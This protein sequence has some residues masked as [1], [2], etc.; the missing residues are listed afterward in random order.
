MVDVPRPGAG[1]LRPEIGLVTR[2]ILESG[3]ALSKSR[4]RLPTSAEL[5]LLDLLW[6]LGEGTVEDLVRVSRKGTPNYKT[7][8]TILRI[9]EGKRLVTHSL[10]GRAFVFRPLVKRTQITRLSLYSLL[11]R[12]FRGSRT[13]L[14]LNLLDDENIDLAELDELEELIRRR[15]AKESDRR[16]SGR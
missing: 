1:E 5:R 3:M 11:G 8:Q 7:V 13:E 2:F 10:R 4:V 14:L 9:M 12:Y 6:T 15:K 16:D